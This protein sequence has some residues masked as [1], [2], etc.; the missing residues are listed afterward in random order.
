[1][2]HSKE[3]WTLKW[4]GWHSPQR[5]QKCHKPQQ[6]WANGSKT[7][8]KNFYSTIFHSFFCYVVKP[9]FLLFPLPLPP[10]S[11]SFTQKLTISA[12]SVFRSLAAHPQQ[13]LYHSNTENGG[14]PILCLMLGSKGRAAEGGKKIALFWFRPRSELTWKEMSPVHL[15]CQTQDSA[16][17]ECCTIRHGSLELLQ[18]FLDDLQAQ[19]YPLYTMLKKYKHYCWQHKFDMSRGNPNILGHH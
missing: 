17:T 13:Q 5:C 8:Q 3:H 1:M 19:P 14:L 9:N 4:Q 10:H 16:C 11:L 6:R 18:V 12:P 2:A 15:S 7:P